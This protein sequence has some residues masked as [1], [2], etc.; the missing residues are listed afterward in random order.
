MGSSAMGFLLTLIN[1]AK[2]QHGPAVYM[3]SSAI[4]VGHMAAKVYCYRMF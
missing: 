1:G 2:G 4:W 3:E